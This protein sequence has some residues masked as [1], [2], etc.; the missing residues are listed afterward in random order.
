MS[1]DIHRSMT[2]TPSHPGAWIKRRLIDAQSMS[3]D[4]FAEMIG[5]SR[6]TLY[7]LVSEKQALTATLAV[8]IEEKSCL[9]AET[10]MTM[11]ATHD[12]WHAR[13]KAGLLL[14]SPFAKES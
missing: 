9:S 6:A 13:K 12:I 8:Q 2:R 3:I 14:D 11:Q 5:T 10:L 4:Q 1:H 7:R